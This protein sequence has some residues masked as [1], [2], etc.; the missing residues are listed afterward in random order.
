MNKKTIIALSVFTLTLASAIGFQYLYLKESKDYKNYRN[1]MQE[2]LKENDEDKCE[3]TA[4]VDENKVTEEEYIVKTDFTEFLNCEATVCTAD[5]ENIGIITTTDY[6]NDTLVNVYL[7]GQIK[8]EDVS[9]F[10]LKIYNGLLYA[11]YHFGGDVTGTS[12]AVYDQNLKELLYLYGEN[13]VDSTKNTLPDKFVGY[14]QSNTIEVTKTTISFNAT[15]I[16]SSYTIP[17][18]NKSFDDLASWDQLPKKGDTV[19][20]QKYT[21]TYLGNSKFSDPKIETVETLTQFYNSHK[22]MDN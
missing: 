16:S 8:I 12:L 17:E 13:E 19:V 22:D 7:N 11:T 10:S 2:K 5:V 14:I 3:V 21:F 4:P 18:T 15:K 6:D 20:T 9:I 1:E